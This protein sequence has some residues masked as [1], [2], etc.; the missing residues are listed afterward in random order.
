M[1][2]LVYLTVWG[3][4]PVV[5]HQTSW[6]E[7]TGVCGVQ[8][9]QAGGSSV[10]TSILTAHADNQGFDGQRGPAMQQM[11]SAYGLLQPRGPQAIGPPGPAPAVGTGSQAA[12][13]WG[14]GGPPVTSW[15]LEGSPD[16]QG[17][18][19]APN[20]MLNYSGHERDDVSLTAGAATTGSDM[21]SGPM[22]DALAHLLSAAEAASSERK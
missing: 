8:Q 1:F 14:P 13:S 6:L 15:G 20:A 2:Q 18:N 22:P 17:R 11:A 5:T 3:V 16:Q 21:S 12:W 4:E 7:S 10:Q 9:T 19:L